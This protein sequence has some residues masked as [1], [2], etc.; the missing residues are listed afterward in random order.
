VIP[1]IM[2]VV[3]VA[4]PHE[5]RDGIV[6]STFI[7][8]I[9]DSL[10]YSDSENLPVSF[11]RG[12]IGDNLW[13]VEHTSKAHQIDY[14]IEGSRGSHH[15]FLLMRRLCFLPKKPSHQSNARADSPMSSR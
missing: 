5:Q 9:I 8:I 2:S 7:E 14:G 13:A 10:V 3:V 15:P 12:I 11:G 6:L 4:L 1:I